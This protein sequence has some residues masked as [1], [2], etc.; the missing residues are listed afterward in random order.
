MPTTM[1]SDEPNDTDRIARI[2]QAV[3][4]EALLSTLAGRVAPP[5]G[6][7]PSMSFLT[8]SFLP[9]LPA[10]SRQSCVTGKRL[11]SAVRNI[12]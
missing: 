1:S 11:A 7:G 8:A 6:E 12:C 2:N 10:L 5:P 3:R 9:A 4:H